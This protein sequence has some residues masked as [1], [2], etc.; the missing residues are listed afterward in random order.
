GATSMTIMHS[1]GIFTHNI[2]WCQCHGS[3]PQ[4][5]VQ[6]LN[7]GL[8]PA[9]IS[10]PQTAFTF[11]VL[12]HFLIDAL[13]C[14]TS[15]M[16]FFP[17]L[18]CLTNNASPDFVLNQYHELMRT[19][20]QFRDLMNRKRFRF[21]HDMKVQPGQGELALFCAACPQSGINMPLSWHDKWLVMQRYIVDGNFTAQH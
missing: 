10:H 14:K 11:E 9:S 5:H 2:F 15:A 6:L 20:H 7:A 16:S 19:S 18:H 21:G 3:E 12:D 8:F 1:I 17:K 4:Q 13:E